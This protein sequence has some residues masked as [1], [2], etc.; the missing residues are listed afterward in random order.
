MTPPAGAVFLDRDGTVIEEVDYLASP[1]EVRL[2]PGAAD[3]IA[4][5][6]ALR[7][8]VVIVTNQAGVA[9]GYF[10]ESRVAEVHA[11]L[12]Q[13]L[14]ARSAHVDRYYV[15]PHHP[16]EG[17]APYLRECDCR[18]PRPG[19][20]LRAAAELRLDLSSSCLIG[21]KLSDLEAGA[22]AGCHTILVRTGYGVRHERE[23][24]A[25]NPRLLA[26]V[27]SLSGAVETWLRRDRARPVRPHPDGVDWP[28]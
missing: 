27:E 17:T 8:P 7:V 6:N 1:D 13:L 22:G 21:D 23:A 3:A 25:R 26:V 12:D 20:L 19:M 14:A 5:L 10:P 15:C 16:R 11:R 9:R 18:K 2:I 24:V 4:R 28:A